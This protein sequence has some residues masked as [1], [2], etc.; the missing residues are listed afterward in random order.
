MESFNVGKDGKPPQKPAPPQEQI[1]TPAD[2]ARKSLFQKKE[3]PPKAV[4]AKAEKPPKREKPPKPPKEPKAPKPP[5]AERAPKAEGDSSGNRK[6]VLLIILVVVFIGV[7]VSMVFNYLN[8]R[9]PDLAVN[10]LRNQ[11]LTAKKNMPPAGPAAPQPGQPSG[12][13]MDKQPGKPIP[14]AA[15]SA[16]E[17]PKL[18]DKQA[19]K[20]P[21]VVPNKQT[22]LPKPAPAAKKQPAK[23]AAQPPALVKI[24]PEAQKQ[25]ATVKS[26]K[27]APAAA[28]KPAP[29]KKESTAGKQ[30]AKVAAA[31]KSASYSSKPKAVSRSYQQTA[32]EYSYTPRQT[33]SKYK[34]ANK[35][36]TV[37]I[38]ALPAGARNIG[39]LGSEYSGRRA[40]DTLFDWPGG[41]SAGNSKDL[42][43]TDLKVRRQERE[44][45]MDEFSS[46][47]TLY[48]VL[49]KESE[50]PD[51]LRSM[52]RKLPYITPQPE[53][54][55]TYSHGRQV[56]WLT[57][58]HYT[59]AEKAYNKATELKAAGVDTT[60]VSEKIYY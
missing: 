3:K 36:T 59:T 54:K 10:D 24:K 21:P 20:I 51:E 44:K 47:K 56:Y 58:G 15:P 31:P 28:A 5:K 4:P 35:T 52:G 48:M 42:F 7:V 50:N 17:L 41:Q 40:G 1:Q 14:P 25:P 30:A 53:I 46:V 16:E 34:K 11:V 27:R 60:V 57:L 55:Q 45:M 38:A 8:S 18:Q 2:R 29:S 43:D 26:P 9:T 13:L 32:R 12:T 6:T 39:G 49:I 33:A 22:V 23:N 37:Q 19:R